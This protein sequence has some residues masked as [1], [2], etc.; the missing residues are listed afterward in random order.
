M[1]DVKL[2]LFEHAINTGHEGGISTAHANT[3]ADMISRLEVMIITAGSNFPI[4]AA[5]RMIGSAIDIIIQLKRINGK[6][7]RVTHISEVYEKD[8]L[9]TIND[10]FIYD[11]DKDCLVRTE[12]SMKKED[13]FRRT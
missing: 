11:Y 7:R 5:R 4:E 9:P 3:P 12:N 10:I 8:G 13:K 2:Y 6:K 1:G